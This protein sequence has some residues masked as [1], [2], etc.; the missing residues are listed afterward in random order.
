MSP[1]G[2]ARQWIGLYAA[3]SAGGVYGF[4][5]PF[6]APVLVGPLIEVF[7]IDERTIGILVGL[8]LAGIAATSTAVAARAARLSLRRVAVAGALLTCLGQLGSIGADAL[9]P[10][11][12]SRIIVG[13]GEGAVVS[14]AFAAAADAPKPD[15]VFAINQVMFSITLVALLYLIPQL[16]ELWGYRAGL[17]S[18]L[19]VFFAT[20]PLLLLL[21]ATPHA[22]SRSDAS[23]SARALPHVTLGAAALAAYLIV[24]FSDIG[25]WVFTERIG[26][27]LGLS[28]DRIGTIL[29]LASLFNLVGCLAAAILDT[30]FGRAPPLTAALLLVVALTIGLGHAPS[31]RVYILCSMSLA[32]ALLFAYPY[33]LG[34]L[35][36]LDE[37]GSW[38]ALSGSA[39][40]V[41]LALGPVVAGHLAAEY[42]YGTMSWIMG[43][44]VFAAIPITLLV[45]RSM[46]PFASDAASAQAMASDPSRG[47]VDTCDSH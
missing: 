10:F 29:A 26:T 44:S 43:G 3:V 37:H 23:A 45:L 6:A 31:E 24:N 30:R 8:E 20:G 18:L 13:L 19:V 27:A 14:A 5:S 12:L 40:A 15:R 33:L 11:G 39:G 46:K 21:P 34:T 2:A 22:A 41:G 1:P 47:R 35:A 9:I 36:A 7:G 25:V 38:T 16:V 4:S 17:S 42:S 28:A 32:A